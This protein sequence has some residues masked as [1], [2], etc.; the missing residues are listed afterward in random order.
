P[1]RDPFIWVA[2]RTSRDAI[3]KLFWR[4]GLAQVNAIELHASA[5]EVYMRIIEAGQHQALA[6]INHAR[7]C[8]A[9][10]VHVSNAA[11]GN[12]PVTDHRDSLSLGVITIY[13]PHFRVG[14][15][16]NGLRSRL[17]H[18]AHAGQ[19]RDDD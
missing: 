16:Q 4:G 1:A 2:C 3:A 7:V 10:G 6:S 5:D 17:R 8:S 11:N 12:D 9:P 14:D 19:S 18:A 15:N 13:C